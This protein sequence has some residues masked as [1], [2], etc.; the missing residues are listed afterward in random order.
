MKH[1]DTTGR[2]GSGSEK[3]LTTEGVEVPGVPLSPRDERVP[4][5]TC[6]TT[7]GTSK[8]I[9]DLRRHLQSLR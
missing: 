2:T 3:R 6:K 9:E 7:L 4:R 8:A 1:T 5:G